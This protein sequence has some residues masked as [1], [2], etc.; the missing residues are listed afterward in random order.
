VAH[1]D[2][3][4]SNILDFERQ[5]RKIADVARGRRTPHDQDIVAG[6]SAYAPPELLYGV[7]PTD[8]GA[9]RFGCDA[10]HLGSMVVYF[11]TRFGAT[12]LLIS[13]M[14]PGSRPGQWAGTFQQLLPQLEDAFSRVLEHF[15]AQVDERFKP[16]LTSVV[17][18]LCCPDPAFRGHPKNRSGNVKQ[19]SV[20]RYISIFDRLATRAEIFHW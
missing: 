19:Y 6:D 10:Y 4:P 15:S 3:K 1:Q 2:T 17:R 5:G 16:E 20:E 9:R 13:E 18:E 7:A 11:F 12:S 14:P 8:Q